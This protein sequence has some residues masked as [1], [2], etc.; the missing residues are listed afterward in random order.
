MATN[1][2]VSALADLM[3]SEEYSDL[4]FACKEQTFKVHKIIVCGQ[5]PVI[6]AA[7]SEKFE[8]GCTNVISM[9]EFDVETV[10]QLVQFFYTGDYDDA[11]VGCVDVNNEVGEA[12]SDSDQPDGGA[13]SPTSMPKSRPAASTESLTTH[14]KVNSIGDYYGVTKL[15]SLANAKVKE[16]IERENERDGSDAADSAW[17]MNLPNATE[18]ATGSTGDPELLSILSAEIAKNLSALILVND[19]KNLDIA[20]DFAFMVFEASAKESQSLMMQIQD[21]EDQRLQKERETTAEI[22]ILKS[23]NQRGEKAAM[24]VQGFADRLRKIV[25]N[26][27]TMA[28]Q[29]S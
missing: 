19:F 20:P 25:A 22:A 12:S 5:S 3:K 11:S 6:K 7:L 2:V 4:T 8:E 16:L 9:H 1:S 27:G 26:V 21:M 10:K 29:V 23:N 28:R 14:I 24:K 17:V 18:L 15:I 13:N